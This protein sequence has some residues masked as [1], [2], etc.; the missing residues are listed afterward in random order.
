MSVRDTEQPL[1][2][3]VVS[4]RR[5]VLRL[6][7]LYS[8]GAASPLPSAL[9]DRIRGWCGF[10]PFPSPAHTEEGLSSCCNSPH[11]SPQRRRKHLAIPLPSLI[12][13][14]PN[15]LVFFFFFSPSC[16]LLSHQHPASKNKD[17]AVERQSFFFLFLEVG[18]KDS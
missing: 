1:G 16:S 18:S 17:R 8:S 6:G 12:P 2:L 13:P 14:L 5:R 11:Q 15:S 4:L 9:A 10:V 3:C 7:F